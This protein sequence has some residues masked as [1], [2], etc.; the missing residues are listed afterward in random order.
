MAFTEIVEL[1]QEPVFFI[2]LEASDYL[3]EVFG[4]FS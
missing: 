3:I 4:G 1:P 2:T